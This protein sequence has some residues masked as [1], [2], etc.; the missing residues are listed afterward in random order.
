MNHAASKGNVDRTDAIRDETEDSLT[1]LAASAVHEPNDAVRRS[2]QPAR[3][4]TPPQEE[5]DAALGSSE[6]IERKSG[7]VTSQQPHPVPSDARIDSGLRCHVDKSDADT[8]GTDAS[9]ES[10]RSDA[11]MGAPDD[12]AAG[13]TLE[14]RPAISRATT[15]ALQLR[16]MTSRG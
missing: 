2:D 15:T 5:A 4:A 3:S 9:G 14:P 13:A 10:V 1:S 11:T 6:G 8:A 16:A 7:H 12:L